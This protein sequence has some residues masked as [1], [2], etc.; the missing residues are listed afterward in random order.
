MY[1]KGA[2]SALVPTTNLSAAVAVPITPTIISATNS[3]NTFF[4]SIPSFVVV[5]I[6][7]HVYAVVKPFSYFYSRIVK[8][9]FLDVSAKT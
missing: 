6:I 1:S 9:G 7:P 3:A 5:K 4:M 8:T 2:N